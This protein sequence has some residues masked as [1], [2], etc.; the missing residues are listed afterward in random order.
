MKINGHV[1]RSSEINFNNNNNRGKKEEERKVLKCAVP[2]RR[3]DLI[4][5]WFND[6]AS[7]L[8][9][10]T[11]NGTT[12]TEWQI[13][14][15]LKWNGYGLIWGAVLEYARKERW[16]PW[17]TPVGRN[18]GCHGRDSKR[19]PAEH[20]PE[21]SLFIR[22]QSDPPAITYTREALQISFTTTQVQSG[23]R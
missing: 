17:E 21:A 8:D 2:R 15:D 14:K 11:L 3:S 1:I 19:S 20:M 18:T 16:K 7:R 13:G 4:S 9:L 12:I 6:A 23:Y 5:L 22:S 10:I